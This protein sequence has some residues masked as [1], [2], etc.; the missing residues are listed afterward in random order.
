M[1]EGVG[2]K[3]PDLVLDGPATLEGGAMCI[4][5]GDDADPDQPSMQIND[6]FRITDDP[7]VA[8]FVFGCTSGPRIRV[9]AP[10]GHLVVEA[11]DPT[12][13]VGTMIVNDGTLTVESGKLVLWGGTA[14]ETSDG[15]YIAAEGATLQLGTCCSENFEVGPTGRMGGP[16][17]TVVS[18]PV[19]LADGAKLDPAVL[20]LP[21]QVLRLQGDAPLSL[22]DVNITGG[23]LNSCG[24]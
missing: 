11:G 22:P 16:G 8:R 6:T 19:T 7:E 24:T 9:N 12:T 3:S 1:N 13:E 5:R 21:F 2:G 14:S 15:A 17:T 18:G 10:D 4:G 23:T 20:D